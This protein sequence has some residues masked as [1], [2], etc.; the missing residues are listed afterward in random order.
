M[1]LGGRGEG[2]PGVVEEGRVFEGSYRAAPRKSLA[3][4]DFRLSPDMFPPVLCFR[5]TLR[6]GGVDGQ[7]EGTKERSAPLALVCRILSGT[8]R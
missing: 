3:L 7:M 6:R 2:G 1:E 8:N 5:Y 4:V